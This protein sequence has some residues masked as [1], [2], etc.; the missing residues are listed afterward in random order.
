MQSHVH[1]WKSKLYN[2]IDWNSQIIVDS[3]RCLAAIFR[4]LYVLSTLIAA[5]TMVRLYWKWLEQVKNS[6]YRGRGIEFL[7]QASIFFPPQLASS[8]LDSVAEAQ[9]VRVSTLANTAWISVP[10]MGTGFFFLVVYTVSAL[11][12]T[13]QCGISLFTSLSMSLFLSVAAQDL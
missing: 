12:R 5:R 10:N 9:S 7:T 1:F 4:I 3:F 11:P 2:L 13:W 6:R 8:L